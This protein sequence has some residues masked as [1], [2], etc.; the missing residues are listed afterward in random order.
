M[1]TQMQT[2]RGASLHTW[3][4]ETDRRPRA[5]VLSMPKPGMTADDFTTRLA[6]RAPGSSTWAEPEIAIPVREP[7]PKGL[8]GVYLFTF[9]P[10]AEGTYVLTVEVKG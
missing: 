2:A 5:L 7:D 10:W 1:T 3:A 9:T 4:G 6:Y 8:P